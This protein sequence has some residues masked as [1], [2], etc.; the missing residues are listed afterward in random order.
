MSTTAFPL[1]PALTAIAIAFNNPDAQ[2]I[3]D[4]VLPRV[5]TAKKF[6]YT[7]YDAAQGYTV[8]DT[9]V[10][11]KS[12]PNMVDFG[13]VSLTDECVDYG[14]D[15]LL[16]NDEVAAFDAMPKPATGG[17]VSPSALSTMM[18]TGLLQ[19]D[20]EVRVA[21][22][23][24]NAA[25]F[26]AGNQATLAGGTQ[27]SDRV[28]SDPLNSITNAM[29]VPLVRPNRMVI[30]QLAWTQLR[31]HPKIVQAVG[32]SAQ[33]AGYASL[34]S[35][36]ELLELQ[37]I[38]VGRSVY[39]TAKKGQAPVYARAWGKH[40]ALL[41]IDSLA[42]QLGQPTFGWTAQF[43][44]RIAGDIAEPKA[45]LRGG[46]RI[47]SGESVKEIVVS[48]EAGYFFQNCVV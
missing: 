2:L 41:H 28:N 27:W 9:K 43:G 21:N 44:S 47:R 1:N 19:L 18:L 11:R 3:A 7:K 10:G 48:S 35:I 20:R 33:T 22:T 40:C 24:F 30:G 13:G 38:I 12:E 4:R 46:V 26:S 39:N 16:P 36:A 8:P 25:S 29:D 32:K 34:E 5:P 17:P 42:A 45:G 37:E 15:D 6:S 14:L 31:Q 23:V